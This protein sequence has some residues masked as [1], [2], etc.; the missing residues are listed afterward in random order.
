MHTLPT[1][2]RQDLKLPQGEQEKA[3]VP[4]KILSFLIIIMSSYILAACMPNQHYTTLVRGIMLKD[5]TL[6]DLWPQLIALSIVG[7]VL[8]TLA[9]N[10]LQKKMD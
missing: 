6:A 8:Y 4:K 10:R 2:S 9:I 3:M 1:L 5:A 7:V